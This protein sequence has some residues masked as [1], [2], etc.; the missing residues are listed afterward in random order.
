MQLTLI[1]MSNRHKQTK[2]SLGEIDE[3][4]NDSEFC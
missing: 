3:M 1:L 2:I 4:F